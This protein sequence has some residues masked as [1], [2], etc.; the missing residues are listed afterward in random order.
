MTKIGVIS[1]THLPQRGMELPAEVMEAFKGVDMI[2]H[3]GDLVDLNVLEQL[4]KIC[5]HVKAVWGNM[6][7]EK[8]RMKLPEKELI[9]SGKYTIGVIHG[10]GAPHNL[11]EILTSA[12]KQDNVDVIIF[13]H[14]HSPMNQ[15][16]GKILFF[17]PGSAADKIFSSQT[18][19]GILEINDEI[20]GKIIEI[21]KG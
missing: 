8:V 16:I 6:D 14:S 20:K 7:P 9:K 21:K 12:F 3:A 10:F 18:S 2:I 11:V 4:R 15:R 13:G 17:N 5:P 1:D 19:C